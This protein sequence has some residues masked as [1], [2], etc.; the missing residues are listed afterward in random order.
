M[1]A[2][3]I[4]SSEVMVCSRKHDWYGRVIMGEGRKIGQKN[5]VQDWRKKSGEIAAEIGNSTLTAYFLVM[6]V[7]YPLYIKNG[8]QEIGNVKFYFFRNV[9]LA[10]MGIMLFVVEI[11]FLLQQKKITLAAYY[12]RLSITDWFLYGFLISLLFSYLFTV[13][14]KEAFWG[15]S[16]WYMGFMSQL[17]FIGIYFGFSR[18][19]RWHDKILYAALGGSTLVFLLGILNRYSI[20][21]IKI[22]GQTPAFIATLGNINWFCGYWAV[23]FPLGVMLYWNS[24]SR[25]RQTAA[26]IYV[27][28]GFLIGVVQGS[29]SA[30]LALAG[31][32][33]LLFLL[34]FRENRTMCRFLEICI[35][36]AISCQTARLCRYLPGTDMNY[37]DNVGKIM[38]DTNL[39]LYFG[40][41]AAILYLAFRL[42]IKRKDYQIA[43]H[44]KI[45]RIGIFLFMLSGIGYFLLLIINTCLPGGIPGLTG[46]QL[47]TFNAA[48][49]SSRGA[50]WTSGWAA[51][52]NMDFLHK[53]V[54]VG[55]DCFAAYLYAVPELAQ[56]A[57][58]QFG[59]SR[60]TNAHNE[61]LTML[62][63]QGILGV[64]CYAGFFVSAFVRFIKKAPAQPILYLCA[65]SILTYTVHNI[66]SF[67]QVLNV[68]FVFMI[69]GAGEGLCKKMQGKETVDK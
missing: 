47:F 53:L 30:Y 40:I 61:W 68:P 15:T 27:I 14:R 9:T 50:T 37:E 7:L 12:K 39:T 6:T 35:F 36:F 45:C 57:Y 29:N 48:W 10:V 20:Y 4:Y 22:S 49:A 55:P 33:I 59:T 1:F 31:L 44:K 41:L 64:V 66:V 32:F 60:L 65:A 28:I 52:I 13:Y 67:Q 69:L 34:S 51:F 18:Y 26:G 8:Y 38:T 42:L 11:R 2:I 24:N 63:N 54:G 5:Q 58:M 17:L 46:R 3:E 23:I 19:F 25:F 21:P 62:V 56:R 16:G 43:Q